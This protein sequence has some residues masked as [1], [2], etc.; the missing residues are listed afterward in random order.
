[1]SFALAQHLAYRYGKISRS[2]APGWKLTPWQIRS[3]SE[4]I[5]AHSQIQIAE[6]AASIGLSAGYLHRAFRA[7][8]G[9]TPLEFINAKR[10]ARARLLLAKENLPIAELALRVGFISPS[11]FARIFRRLTGVSPSQYR[12]H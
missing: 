2:A 6:L 5:E 11:H 1:M 12:K 8:T 7:T 4:Y 3:L 10:I 9:K